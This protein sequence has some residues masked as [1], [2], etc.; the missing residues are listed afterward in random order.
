[1]NG[2]FVTATGTSAGK[3]FVTRGLAR[4][5]H[6][7]ALRV[8]ALKPIETGCMPSAQDALALA[9]ASNATTP[10]EHPDFF[11]AE[12]PLAPYAVSRE[13][14][15]PGPDITAIAAA[16]HAVEPKR[17][18]VLVEGAGGLLVPLDRDTSIADLARRLA[19]P[20]LLVAPDSLGVLSHVLTAFES[21][22]ARA[23][24]MLAVVLTRTSSEEPDL[25][26]QTNASILRERTSLPVL[27]FPHVPD[28][29]D[30]LAAAAVSCGL[31][32]LVMRSG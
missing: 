32:D 3:T 15:Q 24:R 31:L 19:Y 2:V 6:Q 30:K 28:D 21:A 22:Q 29:D 9:R 4:A 16:V 1:M 23:L 14:G 5:L 27:H 10:A 25:S 20:V 7:R 17:D 8:V 12:L 26:S 18:W 11:R 13:I